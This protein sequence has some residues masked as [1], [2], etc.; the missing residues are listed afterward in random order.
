VVKFF[1]LGPCS[2]LVDTPYT[3]SVF[4]F[5]NSDPACIRI[6]IGFNFIFIIVTY[7]TVPLSY[8]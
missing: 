7:G 5:A 2:S 3:P 6:E 4:K 1:V 8:N